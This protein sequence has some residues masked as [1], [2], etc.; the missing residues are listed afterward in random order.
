MSS[1]SPMPAVGAELRD[2]PVRR[3][4][5][6]QI[7][8][9][10]NAAEMHRQLAQ[11]RN[12]LC[13]FDPGLD[14]AV[15]RS[16]AAAI[17]AQ[18][19]KDTFPHL[20]AIARCR[21][22][23][24]R[25]VADSQLAAQVETGMTA[26]IARLIDAETQA[27]RAAVIAASRK[28]E[29]E[30]AAA[31]ANDRLAEARRRKERFATLAGT[32]RCSECGQEIGPEHAEREQSKLDQAEREADA[33]AQQREQALVAAGNGAIEASQLYER[34]RAERQGAEAALVDAGKSRQSAEHRA[35]E[36][37]A[38]FE[39]SF[40]EL[41]VEVQRRVPQIDGDGFPTADDVTSLRHLRGELPERMKERQRLYERR[42]A[43]DI[44]AADIATLEQAVRALGAPPDVDVTR[45]EL[46]SQEQLV[47]NLAAEGR[48]SN[49]A[50]IEAEKTERAFAAQRT[51]LAGE[52][53][54]L[55]TK[56]GRA[57]SAVSVA[58]QRLTDAVHAVPAPYRN[59]PP[60]ASTQLAEELDQLEASSV[61]RDHA[62]M[63]EDRALQAER[64]RQLDDAQQRLENIPVDARRSASDVLAEVTAAERALQAVDQLRTTTG[65]RLTAANRQRT[66]REQAE[67]R[68]ATE[69]RNHTLHDRLAGMLG[70]RGI[71][72][73]L[74]RD[75]E[76]QIIEVANDVLMRVSSGDLRFDPPD[77]TSE[78]S[79]DLTI[80]RAGCPG[81]IGVANLSGGQRF[82]VAVSL[83]L[84][85]CRF[86]NGER[87]PLESIIIDEGF[88]SLDRDGRMA[89]IAEL[90]DGQTLSHMFKKV[91]VVS[92][93]E[94]FAA[95]FP[96][97]YRLR[98]EGATTTVEEF[99][100][101]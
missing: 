40:S 55:S 94:D 37:W 65:D 61:E 11:R 100:V 20:E 38:G 28:A 32:N 2:D 81:P 12:E 54:A 64:Q 68:L 16:E 85:V 36:A 75:A 7:R 50:L 79:F 27:N 41:N 82:R 74:V 63:A 17:E 35:A 91:L 42:Q 99:G 92:H 47:G 78:R 60:L 46:S 19:A 72:L 10:D 84:A 67:Q 90:R 30:Q 3:G 6:D 58:D 101:C 57:E 56:L 31:I 86:A 52:I 62:A 44:C 96:V 9:A 73:H 13:T 8:L 76:R 45:A 4:L 83:A 43:R 39:S 5:A 34:Y 77:P 89:M 21:Q 71:Q 33:Q 18:T 69:E 93:Q 66:D 97:G 70:D 80:R 48:Q 14:S 51:L 88:G 87:R 24:Q 98:S 95:A 29:A 49:E 59:D 53:T 1:Q 15:T 22:Q 26:D 23:Y 25:A